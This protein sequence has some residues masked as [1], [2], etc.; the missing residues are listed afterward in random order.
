MIGAWHEEMVV[1]AVHER[2]AHDDRGE[3]RG[4]R[5]VKSEKPHCRHRPDKNDRDDECEINSD[6]EDLESGVGG[7]ME[8]GH[9]QVKPHEPHEIPIKALQRIA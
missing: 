6:R 4:G 7:G 1:E 8:D 5:A 3:S 2:C 9:R